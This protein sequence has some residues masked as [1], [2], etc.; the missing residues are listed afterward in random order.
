MRA[1]ILLSTLGIL[2]ACENS[3]ST[4]SPNSHRA[5]PSSGAR[6]D[7]QAAFPP[8]PNAAAKPQSGL[9]ITTLESSGIELAGEGSFLGFASKATDVKTCPAGTQAVGG[10]FNIYGGSV[11][12]V[13]IDL[14]GPDGA[15]GWKVTA[16]ETGDA[17]SVGYF[18]VTVVCAQ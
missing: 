9:T 14:S 11:Q 13:H 7:A 10:G 4:T 12:E 5:S 2:A 17:S 8:G 16:R 3:S 1:F 18:K 15:N 6:D